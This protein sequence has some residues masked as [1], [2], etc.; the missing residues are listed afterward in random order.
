LE[1]ERLVSLAVEISD[2]LDAAHSKG[3]V[4]RD[5]KPANIFITR[6][7][8]PKV[9]DFGLAK[10]S[11]LEVAAAQPIAPDGIT[12]TRDQLTDAGVALGTADYMSPEQAL[13]KP[14][15]AR[16]D[17]FSFGAV[18]YEMA[19]GVPPF[20]GETA[21]AIF[22]A[23]L[24]KTP[25]SLRSLNAKAPEKL[26]RVVSRCLQKD[27]ELRYQHAS[28]IRSDLECLKR[29]EDSVLRRRRARRFILPGAALILIA[30]A[31]YLLMP[32]LPPP[33]VSGFVQISNDGRGKGLFQGAMVSDGSRFIL[34]KAQAWRT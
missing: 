16:S 34:R 2:G 15:D 26:E 18:L 6:R 8:N 13:G 7:G 32:P 19:T 3:I 29:S 28:E 30:I 10:I 20:S 33:R 14:L 23:I 21:A 22:D 17:L 5:I 31:S 12:R 4:H 24:H 1:T 27:R 9:L 11:G 25:A